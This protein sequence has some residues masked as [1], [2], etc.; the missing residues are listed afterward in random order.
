MIHN[1]MEKRV[2]KV[3]GGVEEKQVG[4]LGFTPIAAEG[5]QK[6]ST[7]ESRYCSTKPGFPRHLN[8]GCHSPHPLSA[9]VHP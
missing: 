8:P 6:K 1:A 7:M 3:E 2:G 5:G 9:A 4:K